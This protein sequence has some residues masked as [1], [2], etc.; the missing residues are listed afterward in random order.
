M[1][2]KFQ[3]TSEVANKPDDSVNFLHH[4]EAVWDQRDPYG[5]TGFRGVFIS[6]YATLCAAFA[7]IGGMVFGYDQGVVSVILVMPQFLARFTRVSETA[8]GAGFYK[9]LMTAMIELGAF[10]GAFN[11]GWIADKYSRKYSIVIAVV[12]FTIGSIIQTAA[13]DYAMLTVGRLVGGIGIGM[14]SM[15][16][17]LY[18]SEISPPEIRGALLVLEEFCIVFGIVV[19]YWITFGTRYMSGEWAWRLPFLLQ[20]IPSTVLGIGILFL[21]FSPRWLASKGRDSEAL[22]SLGKLRQLPV[23]DQRVQQEWFDIRAEVTFHRQTSAMR[24]PIL[25]SKSKLN[26][27]KLELVSW[28]DCFRTGCWRRTHVGVGLMFFQ[29]F[30]GINALI[31]YSPT[32]FETMGLDYSMQLIMSGVLNVTQLVGVSTSIWTIDRFGRRPLLLWGSFFMTVSHLIIAVFVGKYSQNWPAHRGQGWA[33]AALLLFYMLSFGATWGPVPWA[34]PS[35][36][37]PSSLRAKGVALSTCSN[38]FNNFII[39]LITP[40][41]V[42]NT[43]FGAYTFFAVFCLLSF[44]WTFFFVPETR[45]RTLEQMDHVFKDISSEEEEARRHAIE[46]DIIASHHRDVISGP[47][48]K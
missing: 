34:M 48:D 25:Q 18:I 9:G 19:A 1:E 32:L 42:Q 15:V 30:V 2:S 27:I 13:T 21:P 23:T 6:Y 31:Y 4:A 36:I 7:A 37:F 16:A 39:G 3:E 22:Q 14:L 28:M 29:Q 46:A 12:I 17:P 5:P 47:K 45:G 41:L 26:S 33:S 8:P 24:H 40:P 38:W 11:Q 43:G 20:M 44:V 35:E 10:L